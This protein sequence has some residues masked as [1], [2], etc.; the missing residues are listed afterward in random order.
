MNTDRQNGVPNGR[1]LKVAILG[2]LT[3]LLGVLWT[4]LLYHLSSERRL[5]VAHAGQTVDNLTR[6]YAQQIL[7]TLRGIDQTLL[8]LKKIHELQLMFNQSFVLSD[9]VLLKGADLRVRVV[10]ADGHTI[11]STDRPAYVGDTAYFLT[12]LVRN[13]GRMFVGVP[14][15]TEPNR[16]P[17]ID[18]SRRLNRPDGSFDGVV[19]ISFNPLSLRPALTS[20][21]ADDRTIM[22]VV[23]F[24]RVL[25][26]VTDPLPEV[27]GQLG[28][29]LNAPKL[30]AFREQSPSG[31]AVEP[32]QADDVVRILAWR[33]LDDYP[34]FVA[35]SLEEERVLAGFYQSRLALVA[36]TAGR[37]PVARQDR[38]FRSRCGQ[39]SREFLGRVFRNDGA[40]TRA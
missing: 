22:G 33:T 9:N 39:G 10:G 20:L 1:G 40:Q 7:S 30:F 37:G 3:L 13:D 6:V 31:V 8:L 26:I 19:V 35:A 5:V 16:D 29:P 17:V 15:F 21:G 38:T 18:M 2:F 27:F 32:S 14:E 36:A 28:E 24:D 23:G 4:G 34:L 11:Y 12:H 25:R